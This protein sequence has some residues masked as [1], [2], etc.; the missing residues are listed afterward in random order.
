M[1]NCIFIYY[2]FK[3]TSLLFVIATFLSMTMILAWLENEGIF[4]I[5]EC[6]N[7]SNG[8]YPY[9]EC[10]YG[11][12]YDAETNTCPNPECPV[13]NSTGTYPN[14]TCLHKNFD[15][16]V[17]INECFR[18]CPE[19]STGYWPNCNCDTDEY[20]FDKSRFE[21]IKCPN[22]SSGRYPNCTCDDNDAHYNDYDNSCEKCKGGSVG[23]YPNC[24]CNNNDTYDAYNG[25]CINIS[26]GCPYDYDAS[27]DE[28]KR[29]CL[30]C[31][32]ESV[33]VY[34]DCICEGS[35]T[36]EKQFNY[37]S[38]GLQCPFNSMGVHP[39]CVCEANERYLMEFNSCYACPAES[40]GEYPDCFCTYPL[41]YVKE[42]NVCEKCPSNS[43]GVFPDC[44]CQN[45][46]YSKFH[47]V[48]IECP[49]NSTGL[50]PNCECQEKDFIFSAYINECYIMCPDNSSGIH[51]SC[52]CY[53][54][55]Y[56]DIDEFTCK[57]NVGRSCPVDSIGIGPDCLCVRENKRFSSINYWGC[58]EKSPVGVT[59]GGFNTPSFSNS[60]PDESGKWPQCDASIDQN[61][62]KSLVG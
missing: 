39:N 25:H 44:T 53:D 54:G 38:F 52:D 43:T 7:I 5:L 32:F 17:H 34:P 8:Y 36:Y 40:T 49:V 45:G 12:K 16:S 37:C 58:I 10:K 21:C 41:Q 59:G 51:P 30:Q 3:A 1:K 15:Y 50:Y 20:V 14:C 27:K 4:T 56:Y 18:V 33:G 9:C 2:I 62:L 6:P 55:N 47:K 61:I 29:F 22:D 42:I 11:P 60:C 23:T 19:N 31:P 24:I 28:D 13:N 26:N 35:S 46:L 48:C 57:S